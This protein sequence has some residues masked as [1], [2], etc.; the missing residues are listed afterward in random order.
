MMDLGRAKAARQG[1][2]GRVEFVLGDAERL[3][4]AEASQDAALVGFGIRN[5]T[6]LDQGLAEL[7][8]LLRPG[9]RLAVLEFAT[10]PGRLFGRL[11]DLY[12]ATV[13]PLVSRLLAGERTA[14]DYLVESIRVF[15]KPDQLAERL[16]RAGFER[17]T[18]RPLTLGIAYIHLG[19]KP[20]SGG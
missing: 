17:V 20:R 5:L 11:Y 15:L 14:Y 8:R 12:S 18:Y 19:A 16:T 6:R 10:P 3:P 4:L 9:G 2:A 1:L 13:M 7:Y